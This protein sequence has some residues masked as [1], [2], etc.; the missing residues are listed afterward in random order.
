MR[1]SKID[2]FII[3][4]CQSHKIKLFFD[5][6]LNK[7]DGLCFPDLKEIHLSQKYTN[8]KIKLAVFLHEVSHITINRFKNKPYNN[9]DCEYYSW[10]SAIKLHIKYFGKSF[11]KSQAEFMLKCLKTYCYSYNQFKKT[12][13]I[14]K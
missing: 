10:F 1:L 2:K 4:F 5:P 9:F 3:D 13:D 6:I 11:C 14:E 12:K 7:N 8:Q